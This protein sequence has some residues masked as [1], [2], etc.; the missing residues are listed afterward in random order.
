VIARADQAGAERQH[1]RAS[2]DHRGEDESERGKH[3]LTAWMTRKSGFRRQ[4]PS[5]V[6][7]THNRVG[8]EGES[9]RNQ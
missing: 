9:P 7:I 6:R 8:R 1:D 5:I 3:A 4:A 2:G